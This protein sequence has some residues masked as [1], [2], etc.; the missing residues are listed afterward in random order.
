METIQKESPEVIDQNLQR[1]LNLID[2]IFMGYSELGFPIKL[3]VFPE[4]FL[5]GI[6]YVMS[7]AAKIWKE[8]KHA[9]YIPCEQIDRLIEKAKEYN[10]YITGSVIE[11]D[12]EYPGHLFNT[13]P[14]IG[15][16]GILAKYR[17][18]QTWVP[19]EHFVT[20]PHSI[21][22]YTNELFPIVNTS[23][24]KLAV[25]IC[26][27]WLFPEVTRSYA[28][29]G[30]EILIRV[31]DYPDPWSITP[32]TDWW[33]VINRARAIENCAYVIACNQ[34]STLKDFPIFRHP[35]GSMIVDFE[36]RVI[37]QAQ[38]NQE[39]PVIGPV[40]L[41]ALKEFRTKTN[42]HAGVAHL[43]SEAYNYLQR[44]YYPAAKYLPNE[45]QTLEDVKKDITESKRRICKYPII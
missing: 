8:R 20:S 14:I 24:G 1:A 11:Q 26:Y 7:G 42:M 39:Q 3:I 33:N 30:A 12:D 27:D 9:L 19:L 35:G 25:G 44:S 10:T 2:Y 16:S 4:F 21:K 13:A 40:H 15:P 32:P 17:K 31:S 29:K 45:T 5:Q 18:I 36:G 37:A 41:K 38:G 28:A 23:I 6:P 34:A 43:R 22:G